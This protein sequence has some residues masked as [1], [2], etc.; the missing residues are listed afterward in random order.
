MGKR[1]HYNKVEDRNILSTSNSLDKLSNLWVYYDNLGEFGANEEVKKQYAELKASKLSTFNEI[2]TYENRLNNII[3]ELERMAINEESKERAWIDQFLHTPLAYNTMIHNDKTTLKKSTKEL[4][5]AINFL[6]QHT[7]EYERNIEKIKANTG[8]I[9]IESS[10]ADYV[11][12]EIS[13]NWGSITADIHRL[14]NRCIDKELDLDEELSALLEQWFYGKNQGKLSDGMTPKNDGIVNIALYKALHSASIKGKDDNPYLD[15]YNNLVEMQKQNNNFIKEIYKA[16]SISNLIDSIKQDI[17]K[18]IANTVNK[19]TIKKPNIINNG[20]VK[21]YLYEQF[22]TQA[23]QAVLDGLVKTNNS[24][25]KIESK[26]IG[27]KYLAKTDYMVSA[28]IPLTPVQKI[29]DNYIK[30]KQVSRERNIGAF[31]Q[32]EDYLKHLRKGFIIYSNA[33]NYS[34]GKTFEGFSSGADI[35]LSTYGK[36]MSKN[37]HKNN[38]LQNIFVLMQS[39]G[40]AIGGP[41]GQNKKV[42][43]QVRENIAMDIAFLLFDDVKVIG[44]ELMDNSANAIHLISISGVYVPLSVFLHQLALAIKDTQNINKQKFVNVSLLGLP[45]EIA[46]S[47]GPWG[48]QRW[49]QQRELVLDTQIHTT[50]F[51]NLDE[52]VREYL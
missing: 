52:W 19:P 34:V 25:I 5:D 11:N 49:K 7:S 40:G 28:D 9:T 41:N 46:F 30:D 14:I 1:G 16:L 47:E 51:K 36:S 22:R 45:S 17:S 43:E 10:F 13:R 35:N 26:Q 3:H 12:S 42:I 18:T 44:E 48:Y 33:K 27:D 38:A 4:V 37:S 8:R 20:N 23:A 15:F 21:G 50:F 31:N 2:I 6:M 39:L 29:L 24:N 32:V